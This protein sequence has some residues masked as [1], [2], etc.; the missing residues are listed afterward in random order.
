LIDL[1]L[2]K[3]EY[4]KEKKVFNKKISSRYQNKELKIRKK[5]AKKNYQNYLK[6]ISLHHSINVMDNEI[7]KFISLLPKKSIICDIGGSWGWHWRN[8]D[9]IRPDIKIV[10]VDFIFENLLIAKKILKDKI[11][12]QIFLINDDCCNFYIKNNFFNAIWSVQTLQ[13]IPK[14]NKVYKNIYNQLKNGG[15]FYNCNLNINYL[16]RFIYLFCRKK[17][18]IKGYS[19]NYYLERSNK[20]QKGDLEKVFKNK[21][22]TIY[23]ELLFHPDL[24]IFT[25]SRN[26]VFGKIDSFLTGKCRIKKILARQEAFLIYKKTY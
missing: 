6:E 8:V 24:K 4:D 21:S 1:L 26:N 23:S 12:K 14:Y 9:M 18:L 20:K 15:W 22:T 25:G 5:V 19:N 17:Y 7:K 11:N 16:I 13:H 3:Y 2:K 10:I